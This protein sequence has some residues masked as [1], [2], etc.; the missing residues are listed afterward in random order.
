MDW[1]KVLKV[2]L[3]IDDKKQVQTARNLIRNFVRVH[4]DDK[5]HKM[6]ELELKSVERRL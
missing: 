4:G 1:E 6:L 3:S 2:I 5:G